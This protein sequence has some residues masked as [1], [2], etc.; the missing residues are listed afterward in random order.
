MGKFNYNHFNNDFYIFKNDKDFNDFYCCY[1]FKNSKFLKNQQV[2]ANIGLVELVASSGCYDGGSL[3]YISLLD[4][5]DFKEKEKDK[6]EYFHEFLEY[7]IKDKN[8]K[9]I[10]RCTKK[11]IIYKC[12]DLVIDYKNIDLDIDLRNYKLN[13]IKWNRTKKGLIDFI[14]KIFDEMIKQ[15]ISKTKEILKNIAENFGA[16]Y[17]KRTGIYTLEEIK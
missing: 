9:N 17:V 13:K 14:I 11:Y 10:H 1:K 4:C 5:F 8:F 15:D 12:I 2:F 16:I 6:K 7:I 3:D